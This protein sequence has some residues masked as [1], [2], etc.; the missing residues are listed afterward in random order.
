MTSDKCPILP[1]LFKQ[2]GGRAVF[3]ALL[4]ALVSAC[5]LR[6]DPAGEELPDPVCASG[7]IDGE[8]VVASQ[9]GTIAP[10]L[11]NEF[12]RRYGVDVVEV[13]YESDDE[14]LSRVIAGADPFDVLFV[15]DDL[16]AILRRG[17][18]LHTLDPIALPGMIHLDSDFLG[19]PLESEGLYSVPIVWG[20]V[21]IG[22]NLNALQDSFESDWGMVFD[23]S[24]AWFS[25]G[26]ISLLDNPRQ[27]LAAAMFHLGYSPNSTDRS[28]VREAA[29]LISEAGAHLDGFD[30]ENYA[31]RLINGGLDLAQGRSDD[32]LAALPPD[33][34]NFLYVIPDDGAAIWVEVLTV[35]ITSQHPCSA[36]TFIDFVLEPRMGALTADY[37]GE[38]TTNTASLAYLSIETAANP[39]LYPPPETRDR[40]ELL[41]FTEELDLLYAEE[42][43]L[44][45]E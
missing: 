7:Q 1:P 31:T 43:A 39:T 37:L 2:A 30:S 4:L 14:L 18:S 44:F 20:T 34:A 35:P 12:E 16:A 40:L 9:V 6:S 33:S 28:Q 11:I 17:G 45:V 15:R 13:F 42:Y 26:R 41:H 36:H 29:Q 24:S 5:A 3:L 21:G 22:M 10:T 27:A 8:V 32:F 19:S 38:A 25:A 23:L